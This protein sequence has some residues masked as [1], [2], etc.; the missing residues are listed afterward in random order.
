METLNNTKYFKK[1]LTKSNILEEPP[2]KKE[3]ILGLPIGDCGILVAPGAT[4]KS[5]Y[6]M[7]LLLASCGL[8][9]NHLVK[10]QMKVLYVSLE[11]RIDDIRRRLYSYKMALDITQKKLDET[12]VDFKIIENKSANRLIVKG[13]SQEDNPFWQELNDIIKE[14]NYQLVIIDTLIKTYAGYEENDNV[15]MSLVLSHFDTM[16]IENQC[17]VLLLHHTNKGAIFNKTQTQADARGASSLV[18]NSRF[19]LS[20]ATNEDGLSITCQTVKA[21]FAPSSSCIYNRDYQGALIIE[22]DNDDVA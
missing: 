2:K 21:N 22:E 15:G 11:D 1:S 5:Y 6:V 17:S 4:G 9:E 12:E 10:K 20:L 16:T 13:V 14:G 19:V 3:S 18:D 8:A 7:N